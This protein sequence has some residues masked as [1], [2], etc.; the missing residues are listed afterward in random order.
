MS[1][2]ERI[3]EEIEEKIEKSYEVY[4]FWQMAIKN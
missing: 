2:L 1:I 4:P 3:A